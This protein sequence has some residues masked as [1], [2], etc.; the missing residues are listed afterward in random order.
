MSRVR[1]RIFSG[2]G[3]RNS[4]DESEIQKKSEAQQY[5]EAQARANL[6]AGFGSDNP[7]NRQTSGIFG[8]FGTPLDLS[9]PRVVKTPTKFNQRTKRFHRRARQIFA[10]DEPEEVEETDGST[11]RHINVKWTE[12]QNGAKNTTLKGGCID[13]GEEVK[14]KM[15]PNEI[16]RPKMT[17]KESEKQ[18]EK[19][20]KI[21]E[22][23]W[24]RHKDYE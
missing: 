8:G 10:D 3:S 7:I 4:K 24:I 19:E 5:A 11:C 20:K 23:M 9:S 6:R 22:S 14:T 16:P 1:R 21:V 13:C 18:K 2:T 12:V 15:N 17:G